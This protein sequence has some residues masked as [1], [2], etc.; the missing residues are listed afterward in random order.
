[1]TKKTPTISEPLKK[2]K[3]HSPLPPWCLY[4]LLYKL[5]GLLKKKKE[6]V[7]AIELLEGIDL[8]VVLIY[9]NWECHKDKS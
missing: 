5:V 8:Y 2:K 1:M 6:I 4:E 3:W 9:I 7:R